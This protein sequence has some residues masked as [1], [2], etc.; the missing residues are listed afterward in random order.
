[1]AK[2]KVSKKAVEFQG[3]ADRP[4]LLIIQTYQQM[5]KRELE[6]YIYGL[7]EKYSN[8][9]RTCYYQISKFEKGYVVELQCGGN[10]LG[11]LKTT[12]RHLEENESAVI[13]I[14]GK[15]VM[16]TKKNKSGSTSIT[17][18]VLNEG[19]EKPLTE[20]IVFVDKLHPIITNGY[21]LWRFSIAYAFLGILCMFLGAGMKFV[22]NDIAYKSNFIGSGKLVPITQVNELMM[23]KPQPNSYISALKYQNGAWSREEK[24]FPLQVEVKPEPTLPAVEQQQQPAAPQLTAG[25]SPTPQMQ[26]NGV[27]Q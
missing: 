22:V 10:K 15:K 27:N 1:M 19:D 17:T 14:D 9:L 3:D 6:K 20:D 8:S 7:A 12:L 4:S 16:V 21:A 11:I 24:Q 23:A 25:D 13:E 5:N 18:H 2:L 26:Q